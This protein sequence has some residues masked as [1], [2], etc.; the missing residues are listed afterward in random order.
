[1][2]T[3]TRAAA[4]PTT[5]AAHDHH[6]GRTHARHAAHQHTAAAIGLLQGPGSGLRGQPARNL[7][8]GRQQRQPAAAVGDGFVGDRGDA[9]V[10]Q[11]AG[12][13]GVGG[14]VEVGEEHLPLA[15]ALAFDGLR[16]LD[17]H[18]HL[19]FGKDLLGGVE[20]QAAN[21]AVMVIGEASTHA[22]PGF[23]QDLM[24][25]DDGL[26]SGVGRDTDAEFLRLY[27][28]RA[29]D[30]HAFLPWVWRKDSA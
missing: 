18:D 3:A 7:G 4:V 8:H 22:R 19:G 13:V 17:L 20:N 15:Q 24:A 25:I 11:V 27:L 29:T 2:P 5:P 14:E 23:D 30:L 6:I 28:F 16:F 1:M 10:Q 21:G 12:L 9:T 26:A